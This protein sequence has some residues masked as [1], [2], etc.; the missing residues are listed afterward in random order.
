MKIK[1]TTSLINLLFSFFEKSPRRKYNYRQ[2]LNMLPF[3]VK[4]KDVNEILLLLEQRKKIK[5]IKPGSF[6]LKESNKVLEGILDKTNNGT[7]YIVRKNIEK[8]VYV[9]EK[10]ILNAFDGDIVKFIMISSKSK[11]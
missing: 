8:D 3:Q 7:G 10:N 5:Q 4:K 2:L 11:F 1:K 9:S 6:M